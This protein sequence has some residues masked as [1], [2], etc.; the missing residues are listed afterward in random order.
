MVIAIAACKQQTK[1]SAQEQS[2]AQPTET[3]EQS[4]EATLQVIDFY[5]NWCMPCRKLTPTVEKMEQK[6]AGK[7]NFQRIDIDQEPDLADK[8]GVEAIPTLVFI[9]NGEEV[10]RTVGLISEE[11]L[12]SHIANLLAK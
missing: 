7:I 11:E 2:C 8:F 5:A 6:Y 12:E 4:S 1:E 10:D 3:V 9:C